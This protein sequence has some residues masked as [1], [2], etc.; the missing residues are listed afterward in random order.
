[1][2][3]ELDCGANNLTSLDVSLNTALTRLSFGWNQITSL[4]LSKNTALTELYC[5]DG[6]LTSLDVTQNTALTLLNCSGNELI[7]LDMSKNTALTWLYCS[8]NKISSLD[9]SGA[10]ELIELWCGANQLESLDVSNNLALQN[11]FCYNN[12][13]VLLDVSAN[14]A[15][16]WLLC[17]SNRLVSLNVSGCTALRLLSCFSNQLT[18]LDVSNKR[19]LHTLD[20]YNN[21]MSSPSAVKGWQE[22]NLTINS[23]TNLSAGSFHYYNQNVPQVYILTVI[24]GTGGGTFESNVLVTITAE[25]P[26]QGKQFKDW[27]IIPVVTFTGG[28][29]ATDATVSFIM[30]MQAVT[31][32]ANYIDTENETVLDRIEVFTPPTKRTYFVDAEFEPAGLVVIGY[33]SDGTS[34]TETEY[35]VTGFDS[36][37]PETGQV[38]TVAIGDIKDTFTVDIVAVGLVNIS[39]DPRIIIEVASIPNE[40]DLEYNPKFNLTANSDIMLTLYVAAYDATGRM[41]AISTKSVTM[42]A[43]AKSELQISVPYVTGLKYK[44]FIWDEHF[45]PLTAINRIEDL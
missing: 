33:Y 11:L 3:T 26:A 34:K 13:L 36:S 42:N 37:A 43:G 19:N 30:P 31:A 39:I 16:S 6:R 25:A 12:Q 10:K 28:T 8:D 5:N 4:G 44:F 29:N 27:T 17:D 15:M 38:I 40:G 32:T 24:G 20:C 2:L 1:M 21:N 7:T 35:T 9:V 14:T 45:I 22:L 41:V 18:S 23:P